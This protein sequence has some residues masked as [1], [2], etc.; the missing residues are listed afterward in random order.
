MYPTDN[1]LEKIK[2]WDFP[3]GVTQKSVSEFFEFIGSIQCVEHYGK[4]RKTKK[5]W[6]FAT[7]GWSGNEEIITA[8]EQNY[9][10]MAVCWYLSK[11]GG[12]Y[13]FEHSQLSEE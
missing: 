6:K 2:T 1:E 8:I 9:F 11:R 10:F 3:N 4:L 5:F 12:L 13:W 7:G